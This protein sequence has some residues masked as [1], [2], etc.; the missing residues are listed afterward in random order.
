MDG[1]SSRRAL[2]A[3]LGL[4]VLPWSIQLYASGATTI[5]FPWGSVTPSVASVTTLAEF[6]LRYTAGL[7]GWLYAWPIS[8]LLYGLGVLSAAVGALGGREDVRLTAGLLVL[9]GVGN[10]WLAWGFSF[11]PGRIAIPVGTAA[12]W[13]VVW[14]VY[15]PLVRAS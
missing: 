3:V 5:L 1:T 14:V 7:P 11:Q 2:A 4:L 12:L 10:L 13:G 8:A 15:R 9:A 6:L